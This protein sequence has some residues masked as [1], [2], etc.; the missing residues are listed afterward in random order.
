MINEHNKDDI[1]F[2][3]E[4]NSAFGR[5]CKV[6]RIND[7]KVITYAEECQ[8]ILDGRTAMEEL[9]KQ[10]L[11]NKGGNV[12]ELQQDS[13]QDLFCRIIQLPFKYRRRRS[14][15]FIG[16]IDIIES[17]KIIHYLTTSSID[18]ILQNF[19]NEVTNEGKIEGEG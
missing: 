4:M 10:L 13:I 1:S 16:R 18:S 17:G 12:V 14:S 8:A 3:R 6:S 9:D 2:I 15:L 7:S 5:L 19:L 11:D